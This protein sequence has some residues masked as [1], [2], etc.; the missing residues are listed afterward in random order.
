MELRELRT[1]AAGDEARDAAELEAV[2]G[3]AAAELEAD[4]GAAAAEL[5]AKLDDAIALATASGNYRCTCSQFPG[6]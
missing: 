2:G 5:E 4:G 6:P 3:A 1:D